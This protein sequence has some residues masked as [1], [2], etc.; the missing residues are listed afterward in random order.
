MFASDT[1][2]MPFWFG[3]LFLT[4]ATL[5]IIVGTWKGLK[6]LVRLSWFLY[7]GE[8]RVAE[9]IIKYVKDAGW[10]VETPA[11][12]GVYYPMLLSGRADK[13]SHWFI[14]PNPQGS[15]EKA[16]IY[17]QAWIEKDEE[18]E[19]F[20]VWAMIH[21]PYG[22]APDFSAY[23][24]EP[25]APPASLTYWSSDEHLLEESEAAPPSMTTGTPESFAFVDFTVE[26]PPLYVYS[27]LGSGPF[28]ERTREEASMWSM[29]STPGRTISANTRHTYTK[30]LENGQ[31]FRQE[32]HRL[33][34]KAETQ[35][36]D[37]TLRKIFE[38]MNLSLETL[39]PWLVPTHRLLL[40]KAYHEFPTP[41]DKKQE[42][43]SHQ[44]HLM[45]E[46]ADAA[47][48]AKPHAETYE[49]YALRCAELL[50]EYAPDAQETEDLL[51]A[52]VRSDVSAFQVFGSR[53]LEEGADLASALAVKTITN[54]NLET[55]RRAAALRTFAAFED[56]ERLRA[57]CLQVYHKR[58][59]VPELRDVARQVWASSWTQ[60]ELPHIIAALGERDE[61]NAALD[62]A[63]LRALEATP[64]EPLLLSW[65]DFA[66]ADDDHEREWLLED[67][68]ALLPS[69][70]T[71]ASLSP[72][73]QLKAKAPRSLSD[74]IEA[75]IKQLKEDIAPGGPGQLS[76]FE[77]DDVDGG[78]SLSQGEGG[79]LSIPNT[80]EEGDA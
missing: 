23:S 6:G 54:N 76:V 80:E 9:R 27:L 38:G 57:L 71:R 52:F 34:V 16:P 8:R 61:A 64:E 69:V 55:E 63:A 32:R 26:A 60:E 21:L 10:E 37:Q 1:H 66:P 67:V 42:K 46:Q 49:A 78:L 12:E 48:Y 19:S 25:L 47:F 33:L 3:M 45:L 30:W 74:D 53:Y 35:E 39:S 73:Q 44:G 20:Q 18:K 22:F 31:D 15:P 72:L 75:L 14:R 58:M 51:Q 65:L 17:G 7:G 56:K 70:M 68:L 43:I 77:G 29:A 59:N 36:P 4:L 41:E 40:E 5:G 79:Q 13:L 50:V 28:H 11:E 62:M 24:K 2:V